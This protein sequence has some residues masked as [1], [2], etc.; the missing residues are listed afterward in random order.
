MPAESELNAHSMHCSFQ[1]Y[2]ERV[3]VYVD[4]IAVLGVQAETVDK[5]MAKIKTS[6]NNSG[7]LTHEPVP[8]CTDCEL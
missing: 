6:P 1:N 7:L 4:N 2:K 5:R 8:A 3:V